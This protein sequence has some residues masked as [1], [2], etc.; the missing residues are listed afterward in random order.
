MNSKLDDLRDDLLTLLDLRVPMIVRGAAGSLAA[1][2]NCIVAAKH[3]IRPNNGQFIEALI[4]M[5][6]FNPLGD[7]RS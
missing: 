1:D 5:L 4:S 3:R 2:L 7:F 6:D